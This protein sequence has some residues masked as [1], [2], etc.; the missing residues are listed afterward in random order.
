MDKPNPDT[1]SST[2]DASS[3]ARKHAILAAFLIVGTFGVL[4]G[5]MI[6]FRCGLLPCCRRRTPRRLKRT[7]TA[8]TIEEG[9]RHLACIAGVPIDVQLVDPD[10]LGKDAADPLSPFRAGVPRW[11]NAKGGA[12]SAEELAEVRSYGVQMTTVAEFFEK[13]KERMLQTLKVG[14]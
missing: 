1:D 13:N 3:R 6:C 14:Q 12:L 7:T 4:G 8:L 9:L 10:E 11:L 5:G 2:S